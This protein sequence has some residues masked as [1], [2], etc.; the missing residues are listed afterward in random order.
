MCVGRRLGRSSGETS[1][2]KVLDSALAGDHSA[3]SKSTLFSQVRRRRKVL[4]HSVKTALLWGSKSLA[5]LAMGATVSR[6]CTQVR[7]TTLVLA[8]IFIDLSC[9]DTPEGISSCRCSLSVIRYSAHL[10]NFTSQRPNCSQYASHWLES[11][12]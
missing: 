2:F 3:S 5:S 12:T 1:E 4:S 8:N 10:L 7:E 11:F 9:L 6:S